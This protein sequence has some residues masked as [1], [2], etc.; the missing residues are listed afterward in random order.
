[1][2]KDFLLIGDDEYQIT[3]KLTSG[4]W[5]TKKLHSQQLIVVKKVGS[6][7]APTDSAGAFVEFISK[8][9]F[10]EKIHPITFPGSSQEKELEPHEIINQSSKSV[11]YKSGNFALK[12]IPRKRGWLEEI[13]FLSQ[14]NS[15]Y[16]AFAETFF[17]NKRQVQ[18][19]MPLY[20]KIVKVQDEYISDLAQAI[21]Y[22][23]QAGFVHRDIKPSNF[24]L[25]EGVGVL[26]DLGSVQKQGEPFKLKGTTSSYL[27]PEVLVGMET[28][29]MKTQDIWAFGC[30]VYKM[31]TQTHPFLPA[32]TT[33]EKYS[34]TEILNYLQLTFGYVAIGNQ[35]V[36]H[37][38]TKF[39]I[40]SMPHQELLQDIFQLENRPVITEILDEL[41]VKHDPINS[42]IQSLMLRIP[43]IK[44]FRNPRVELL[45]LTNTIQVKMLAAVYYDLTD[46]SLLQCTM[47]AQNRDDI[48]NMETLNQL[49]GVTNYTTPADLVLAYASVYSAFTS[50]VALAYVW[51]L[52]VYAPTDNFVGLALTA[53][54]W[55]CDKT[56]E[57]FQ[58]DQS[59]VLDF[60]VPLSEELAML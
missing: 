53:V 26:I 3:K 35:I 60:D 44:N 49:H 32:L 24:M 17:F 59:E 37:D 2:L 57:K 34:K 54:K 22:L 1:M 39:K 27:A 42:S 56:G 51:Q 15:P 45:E 5:L 46:A 16:L 48:L 7:F 52:Y 4:L 58:Q 25:K 9:D 30:T 38:K 55:A 10:W 14:F 19:T 43:T 20:E 12:V 28:R 6:I 8:D 11:V 18:I 21:F 13:N 33:K 40:P 47:L 31:Y 29:V 36:K 50:N 23:H 41:K